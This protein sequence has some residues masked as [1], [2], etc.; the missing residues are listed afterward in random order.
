MFGFVVLFVFAPLV[1][2]LLE[3]SLKVEGQYSIIGLALVCLNWLRD[4]LESF[5]IL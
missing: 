1:L 2:V 5:A 3:T 4:S